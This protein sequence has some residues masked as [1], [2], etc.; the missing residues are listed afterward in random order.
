[1]ASYPIFAVYFKGDALPLIE[2]G[3]F[4]GGSITGDNIKAINLIDTCNHAEKSHFDET[5]DGFIDCHCR[6]IYCLNVICAYEELVQWEKENNM[7]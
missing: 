7:L 2:H 3:G 6:C 5:V 1:M 4:S